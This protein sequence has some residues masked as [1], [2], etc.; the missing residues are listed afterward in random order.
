MN[1]RSEIDEALRQYGL[2][3]AA[4]SRL[5]E[6]LIHQTYLVTPHAPER[7]HEGRAGRVIL[8][9]LHAQLSSPE[10]LEDYAA[11]TR[12]LAARGYGGPELIPTLD[13]ALSALTRTRRWR[14]SS[15]VEGRTL[16]HIED[17]EQARRGGRALAEFHNV[18]GDLAHEFRSPHPGHDTRGHARRL[19]ESLSLESLSL[20]SR[21]H[22][23]QGTP[24]GAARL[25]ARALIEPRAR[26]I[27]SALEGALLPESLPRV[28]V[29]GDPKVTNLRF[30]GERAVLI[31]LDTCG[32]H[33]RLVDI[34]DAIRSWCDLGREGA[35]GVGEGEPVFSLSRCAALLEGYLSGSGPL[36]PLEREWLPRC[37]L[38]ITLELA[39]RF[40]RDYIEDSYFAFDASRFESRRAHNLHRVEAMW[41]LAEEMRAAEG[42]LRRLVGG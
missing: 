9:G 26:Q 11:V 15:F 18:I 24:E 42:A 4:V 40:A 13:G 5:T 35:R 6:G 12:H 10:T 21:V 34:G 27:L 20:E 28:V 41:R 16:P 19:L 25:A 1:D 8:Q 22:H 7:P 36:A 33:T 31:D 3:G 39:A 2:E 32:R 14:L 29:H 37:G 23:A 30:Q 38:T 17:E